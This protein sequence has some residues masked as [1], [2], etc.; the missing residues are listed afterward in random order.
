MAKIEIDAKYIQMHFEYKTQKNPFVLC[1]MLNYH[2]YALMIKK[3][4]C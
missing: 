2:Y 3:S 1:T 4:T